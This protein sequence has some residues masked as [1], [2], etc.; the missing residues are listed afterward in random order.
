MKRP[1]PIIALT[2]LALVAGAC[3]GPGPEPT[4]AEVTTTSSPGPLFDRLPLAQQIDQEIKVGSDIEYPPIE[5]FKEGTE[6]VQGLDYDLAQALGAKLGVRMTFVNSPDFAGLIGSLQAGRFDIVMSAMND[7]AERRGNGVDFIDYFSAG[8]SI[9]VRKGNPEHI[10]R[11]EDLCGH[12]VAVQKGTVQDTDI[13]TPQEPECK[14]ANKPLKVLR[15]DKDAEALQQVKNGRA[16][17]NVED[18]PVAAYNA[19]T[20]GRGADFEVVPGQL[21]R[22]GFY[23][24]AVDAEDTRLRDALRDALRAVIDDGT[25]DR[26]LAK[27][28]LSAGA[29]KTAAINGGT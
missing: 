8:S 13:L 10:T 27:W 3:G 9:L 18:F 7:T 2:L 5:F 19:R 14:K 17:A 11:V 15:F 29:L 24:I 20:S 22:V 12:T 16:V 6:E 23:G 1:A 4:Q 26:I 25:Y 28:N 21:G